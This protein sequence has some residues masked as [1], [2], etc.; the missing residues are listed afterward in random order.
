MLKRTVTGTW[1]PAWVPEST[2]SLSLLLMIC[3]IVQSTVGYCRYSPLNFLL[4]LTLSRLEA[5]MVHYWTVSISYLLIPIT[6]TLTMLQPVS[7]PP[8]LSSVVFLARLS[9]GSWP[10]GW[11][12]V[13]LSS[14]AL[15]SPSSVWFFKPL[16][17]I[18]PCSSS[19]AFFWV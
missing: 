11:V 13:Q 19:H 8:P 17:R 16:L 9:L 12:V 1:M 2:L 14:G 7:I 4:K 10:T 3:S 5:T 6:S 18:S 15:S